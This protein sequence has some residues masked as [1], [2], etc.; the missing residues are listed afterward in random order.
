M[1]KAHLMVDTIELNNGVQMPRIGY[2]VY[3]I[4]PS[5]TERCVPRR[6]T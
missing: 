5:I 6:E 3:Q 2:G 4:P 1:S